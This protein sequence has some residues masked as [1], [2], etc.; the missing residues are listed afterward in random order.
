[1]ICRNFALSTLINTSLWPYLYLLGITYWIQCLASLCIL[2]DFS[3]HLNG[4]TEIPWSHN[5]FLVF[6]FSWNSPPASSPSPCPTSAPPPCPANPWL[7]RI[8]N[9]CFKG[10]SYSFP[11]F[12][13]LLARSP[14]DLLFSTLMNTLT[15]QEEEHQVFCEREHSLWAGLPRVSRKEGYWKAGERKRL[16]AERE[17]KERTIQIINSNPP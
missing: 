10:K 7:E 6:L 17:K 5:F 9:W 3:S 14:L 15:G 16:T 13:W 8:D 11:D 1:M 2:S 12:Y 4:T